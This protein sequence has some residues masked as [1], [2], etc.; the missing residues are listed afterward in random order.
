MYKCICAAVTEKEWLEKLKELGCENTAKAEL[1]V[2]AGCGTCCR[3]TKEEQPEK[4]V[5]LSNY[6]EI[7]DKNI[8]K[9]KF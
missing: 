2:G 3:E 9:L 4:L 6:D 7:N 8:K 5:I 1:G